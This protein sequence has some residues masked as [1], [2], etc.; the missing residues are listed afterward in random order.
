MASEYSDGSL[1]PGVG[2]R[3]CG[4]RGIPVDRFESTAKMLLM[5][6]QNPVG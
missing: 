4:L 1:A 6:A 2:L 3:N 5:R